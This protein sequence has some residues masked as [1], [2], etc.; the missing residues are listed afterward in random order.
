MAR[1]V[2]VFLVLVAWI[3]TLITVVRTPGRSM[4]LLPKW[5]WLGLVLL[6]IGIPFYWFLGRPITETGGGGFPARRS[7]RAPDDDPAFMNELAKKAWQE[8]MKK[9]RGEGGPRRA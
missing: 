4:R 5:L 7:P 1:Y 9:R 3:Y 6:V 8:R 2:A